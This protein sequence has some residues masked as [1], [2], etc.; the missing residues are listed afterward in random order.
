MIY[1]SKRLAI[2]DFPFPEAPTIATVLP[3]GI[4][5]LKSFRTICKQKKHKI[6]L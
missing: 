2:V 6:H 3:A 5:K 4:L 1:L